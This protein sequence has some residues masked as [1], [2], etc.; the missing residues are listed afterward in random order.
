MSSTNK[1][2]LCCDLGQTE[3]NKALQL[4]HDIVSGNIDGS[5]KHP[6]LLFVE[7]PPVFT[8][9]KNGGRENLTVSD[10]FLKE[11]H[12]RVIQIERGGNITYHG[13]GQLVVYPILNMHQMGLSVIDFVEGLEDVMIRTAGDF[14]IQAE[15]NGKNRGVWVGTRKLGSIGIAIRRGISFHGLA[16]NVNNSLVPFSWINPCGLEGIGMTSLKK[17]LGKELNMTLVK[18]SMKKH[19]STLFGSILEETDKMVFNQMI[20]DKQKDENRRQRKNHKRKAVVA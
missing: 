12:I 17:E 10:A 8:L 2:I 7:H 6:V 15:R 13:P 11:K 1:K 18:K 16:L 20:V 19:F 5:L 3:Y 9:G 4:Q 14:G